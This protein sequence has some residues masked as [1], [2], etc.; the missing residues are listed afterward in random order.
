MNPVRPEKA[1]AHKERKGPEDARRHEAEHCLVGLRVDHLGGGDEH[2]NGHGHHDDGDRLVLALQVGQGALLDRTGNLAHGGSSFV[3][4]QDL[5]HQYQ[6]R[7]KRYERTGQGEKEPGP[8]GP[9]QM[10]RQVAT[11]TCAGD[12][13]MH[14][15]LSFMVPPGRAGRAYGRCG[16]I[17]LSVRTGS[18]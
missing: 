7:R 9:P 5:A 11:R 16:S 18:R 8:F 17:V 6:R 12:D 3:S 2:E 15:N 4:G 14:Q 10:E 1:R 13:V